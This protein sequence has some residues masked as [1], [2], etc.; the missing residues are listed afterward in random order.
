MNGNILP[1][2][3]ATE[4]EG[5]VYVDPS[6][7]VTATDNFIEQLRAAQQMNAAQNAASTQALGTDAQST[8]GGLGGTT[9]YWTSRYQTPQTNATVANLRAA[10]QATALNEALANE[11]AMWDKRYQEAYRAYQKRAWDKSN[12]TTNSEDED[13]KDNVELTDSSKTIVGSTPGVEGGQTVANIDTE[14]GTVL[15]YTG[16]PYGEDGTTNYNY[17][18]TSKY[19]SAV[20]TGA[21]IMRNYKNDD[22][23]WVLEW[24]LPSGKTVTTGWGQKL[25]KSDRGG[26]Y[27]YDEKQNTYT[28]A[29]E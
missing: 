17:P 25:M 26:Y 8:L 24:E 18:L 29:G 27:V 3:E 16:V 23:H 22:G 14:T 13:V 4:V 6:L 5:R 10:A 19:Y 28:Y 12:T 20:G 2:N 1:S 7:G 11:K 9:S 15:G 21:H